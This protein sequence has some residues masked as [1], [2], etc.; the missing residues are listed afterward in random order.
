[1]LRYPRSVKNEKNIVFTSFMGLESSIHADYM[2][3]RL[4]N[5]KCQWMKYE[6]F[7]MCLTFLTFG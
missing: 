4:M 7:N 6:L 3:A 1:M 5:I 2:M